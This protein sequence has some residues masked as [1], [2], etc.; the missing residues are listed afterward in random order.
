L[1]TE[2]VLLDWYGTLAILVAAPDLALFEPA[3]RLYLPGGLPP[4]PGN[5]TDPVHLPQPALA[6]TLRRLADAGARD[7]YEG[8]L[9]RQRAE[10]LTAAG[11]ALTAA[12]LASYRASVIPALELDYRGH[13]ISCV[14]GLSGGPALAET[15]S[16]LAERGVSGAVPGPADYR[17]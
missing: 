17:A 14:P 10:E 15:L 11:S 1:A 6:R 12:D 13:R 16:A 3:R 5:G 4:L 7:F 9:A 8:E 2:G